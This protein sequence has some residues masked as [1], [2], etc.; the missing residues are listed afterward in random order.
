MAVC[1]IKTYRLRFFV[2]R[3]RARVESVASPKEIHVFYIDYG[4]VSTF[5]VRKEVWSISFC[6]YTI[7]C[8]FHGFSHKWLIVTVYRWC[9][10]RSSLRQDRFCFLLRLFSLFKVCR[11]TFKTFVCFHFLQREVLPLSKLCPLPSAFHR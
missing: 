3:Y 7:L 6:C 8:G 10:W 4:N 2:R 1:V 11:C 5:V 9:W